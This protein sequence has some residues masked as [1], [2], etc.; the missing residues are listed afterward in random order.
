[1]LQEIFEKPNST[2]K[3]TMFLK[4]TLK[5]AIKFSFP[6]LAI[7]LVAI[8][9]FPHHSGKDATAN[10]QMA[11]VS[12]LRY[13]STTQKGEHIE[14]QAKKGSAIDT[15]TVTL[16]AVAGNL[17]GPAGQN[18]K[19]QADKGEFNKNQHTVSLKGNVELT[20][21]SGITVNTPQATLN[22]Q[23]G[24]ASG[25]QTITAQHPHGQIN[26]QSFEVDQEKQEITFKGKP[27]LVFEKP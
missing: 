15:D 25:D 2:I 12:R 13:T 20:A 19:L 14:L 22:M 27:T 18:Y 17:T 3:A 9:F 23:T 16:D 26:S 11:Q 10:T 1:M 24:K 5:K 4:L 21:P 7:V 6:A 8:T